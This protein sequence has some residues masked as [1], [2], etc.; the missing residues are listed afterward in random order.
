MKRYIKSAT[1]DSEYTL[2]DKLKDLSEDFDYITSALETLER[3]G[4]EDE[5]MSIATNVQA[6]LSDYIDLVSRTIYEEE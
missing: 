3:K 4:Y 5:A 2:S 6:S 1:D